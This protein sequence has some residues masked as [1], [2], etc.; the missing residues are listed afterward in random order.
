MAHLDN[1]TSG[2]ELQFRAPF[3]IFPDF[4]YTTTING[5]ESQF[6]QPFPPTRGNQFNS[7]F[8]TVLSTN[9]PTNTVDWNSVFS[10][11][12]SPNQ[13]NI[14]S[15]EPRNDYF[16]N[17][18]YSSYVDWRAPDTRNA[19]NTNITA[20]SGVS[21]LLQIGASRLGGLTGIPQIT[22]GLQTFLSTKSSL[23]ARYATLSFNQLNNTLLDVDVNIDTNIIGTNFASGFGIPAAP[24][25]V[26]FSADVPIKYPDFRSR[27][28]YNSLN[29]LTN[30]PLTD[31][32]R[33]LTTLK[34]NAASS[35]LLGSKTSIAYA[36]A[37]LTPA[38]AYSFLNLETKYG[39]GEHDDPSAIRNDFTLKSHI[40]TRWSKI[41]KKF[42][43]I[44]PTSIAIR[45]TAALEIATPFRG[46]KVSVIDFHKKQKLNKAYQ[47]NPENTILGIDIPNFVGETKDFIKF[48]LTG[49][50][51]APGSKEKDEIIVFRSAI[52][53][54]S[55][56]FSGEW[57]GVQMIGRA[58]QNYNYGGY[59]RSL[60]LG[61]DVYATDR[62]E[63]KPIWRKLNA[64]AG[65]TAPIYDG[66]TIAMKGPWMR[67]TVGDMFIQTPVLLTS[68]SYDY[69]FDAP[70]EINVEEDPEMMQLPMKISV[71]CG[72]TVISNEIP[73]Q[74]GRFFGLAK[75]FDESGLAKKGTKNWLSDFEGNSPAEET[76]AGKKNRRRDQRR[77]AKKR[78]KQQQDDAS[79]PPLGQIETPTINTEGLRKVIDNL[80]ANRPK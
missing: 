20:G 76:L 15:T 13:W 17:P 51:L 6:N 19:E 73:Q 35:A 74:N 77:A 62:D 59:S 4:I 18:Q 24:Q 78:L 21:R 58:D 68:L 28:S 8:N 64:L 69:S 57:S 50:K 39:W 70:W 47:W 66:T 48:Y 42:Q 46:D 65:Y 25:N 14:T 53:T 49:P 34:A 41:F 75:N 10:N 38:G 67:I 26:S 36:A 27:L 56:S 9:N 32:T 31:L 71:T 61:F 44:G 40:T 43:K 1:T 2:H 72:F 5:N 16:Y 60:S 52:T 23:S 45:P 22:Q 29:D 30:A 37:S 63:M 79:R 3:N 54:L 80:P 12:Q 7:I 33:R 11:D 55:D